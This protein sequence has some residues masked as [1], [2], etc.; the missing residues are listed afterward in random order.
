MQ[1][2]YRA[3]TAGGWILVARGAGF[4][5]LE[6]A[7]AAFVDAVRG[8]LAGDDAVEAVVGTLTGDGFARTP[9][10]ALVET[11]GDTEGIGDLRVIVRGGL[12]LGIDDASGSHSV[13]GSGVSTWTER[14]FTA[15]TSATLTV[16]GASGA[17]DVPA[18]VLEIGDALVASVTLGATIA[19]IP[20]AALD[21]GDTVVRPRRQAAA[22]SVPPAESV[23]SPDTVVSVLDPDTVVSVPDPDTVAS[24]PDEDDGAGAGAA[25][26][27]PAAASG[28]GEQ[29]P[30]GDHDGDTVLSSD[31]PKRRGATPPA[32]S[33]APTAPTPR[34]EVAGGASELLDRPI[35]VGRAPS[36]SKV[37]GGQMP[38]LVTVG[39]A[40]HD[41]SRNHAQFTL[42]GGTVVV[43]DLH[44]RNGTLV[45]LP[46]KGPQKL[47]AGEPTAV[48]AGTVVDFG[49]GVTMTVRDS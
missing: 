22:P 44:S 25:T 46:G 1:V 32:T 24:V 29:A 19:A 17:D 23:P 30:L 18:L 11:T 40:D 26:E 41:I 10:F 12:E 4:V 47:R 8:A 21:E 42:E 49:G 27:Q 36:V 16:P 45:V 2:T 34:L 38:R 6:P 48:I 28:A 3:A 15:V 33:S 39:T 13:S 35:L 7:A 43:T 31:L 14:G 20:D 9:S 37:P 5:V